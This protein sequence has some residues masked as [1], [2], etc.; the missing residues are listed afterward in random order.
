MRTQGCVNQ[1]KSRFTSIISKAEDAREFDQDPGYGYQRDRKKTRTKKYGA[2][3][4]HE[5]VRVKEWKKETY[6]FLQ[7]KR[8]EEVGKRRRLRCGKVRLGPE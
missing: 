8:E 4:I 3:Q 2:K 1:S 6:E 5:E 7:S